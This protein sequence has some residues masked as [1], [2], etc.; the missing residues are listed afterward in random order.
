MERL[1]AR[2]RET[3]EEIEARVLRQSYDVPVGLQVTD[4]RNDGPLDEAIAA[5]LAVIDGVT[6]GYG[7]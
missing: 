2:G 1:L 3:R 4:I 7:R 5:F 6:P